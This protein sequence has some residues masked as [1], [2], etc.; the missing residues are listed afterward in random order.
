M[1]STAQSAHAHINVKIAIC[2]FRCPLYTTER[3]KMLDTA[4]TICPANMDLKLLLHGRQALDYSENKTI[5]ECTELY[6]SVS[7]T[8]K[9]VK[10]K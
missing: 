10:A 8:I 7:D 6:I 9:Y 4:N 3:C 2:L 5:I 1:L